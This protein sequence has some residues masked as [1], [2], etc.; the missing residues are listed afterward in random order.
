MWRFVRRRRRRSTITKHYLAHKEVA[1]NVLVERAEYWSAAT[2]Y[3]Y[4]R[5]SIRNQRWRWASC[6]DKGNLNFSYKLIFLPQALTDYI[7]VHELCHLKELNHG[8]RFWSLVGA[9]VPDYKTRI[10]ELRRIEKMGWEQY[11]KEREALA[12]QPPAQQN[13][14]EGKITLGLA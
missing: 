14:E 11:F 6:T 8:R 5:I 9:V 12:S 10:S 13:A 3:R 7:I 2:G 1:R 4:N